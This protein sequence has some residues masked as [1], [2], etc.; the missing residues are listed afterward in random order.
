[1]HMTMTFKY[2]NYSRIVNNSNL[3][4]LLSVVSSAISIRK[5]LHLN[6]ILPEEKVV[7]YACIVYPL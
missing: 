6:A 3:F 1:M 7:S 4:I 5:H 2:H